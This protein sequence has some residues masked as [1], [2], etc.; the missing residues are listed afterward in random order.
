MTMN[1]AG[2]QPGPVTAAPATRP[3]Q[4]LAQQSG[5]LAEDLTVLLRRVA[6]R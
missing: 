5:S 6:T 4:A 2:A 1:M 3:R